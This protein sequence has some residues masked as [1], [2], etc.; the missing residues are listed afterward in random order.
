[1]MERG[2]I[3]IR[4]PLLW[5]LLPMLLALLCLPASGRADGAEPVPSPLPKMA[6]PGTIH[7]AVAPVAGADPTLHVQLA[8]AIERAMAG[9]HFIVGRLTVRTLDDPIAPARLASPEAAARIRQQAGGANLLVWGARHGDGSVAWYLLHLYALDPV[10]Q[11]IQAAGDRPI[12]PLLHRLPAFNP[13]QPLKTTY[14]VLGVAYHHLG[15][16]GAASQVLTAVNNFPDLPLAERLPIAF[17]LALSDLA[18]G[19]REQDPERVDN[20]LYLFGAL[21]PVMAGSGNPELIGATL[22]N[23]G[24][25]YRLHPTR[26]GPAMLDRAVEKFEQALPYYPAGR[27][28]AVRARILHNIGDAEQ[29]HPPDRDGYHL[30]RALAAY[31]KALR[32]WNERDHPDAFRAALHNMALCYQ[33]L[34]VGDRQRNLS[35]AIGL[36][37]RIL[38][39]PQLKHRPEIRAA[40]W[41]NLGQAYQTLEIDPK[42]QNL[43]LAIAAYR[44]A[45]RYW[46]A[47]RNPAQYGRF[48]QLTG[49][50]FQQ[51]PVGDRR[52]NLMRAVNH[53]D[54]A[55]KVTSHRQQ[56]M[57]FAL[58]QVKRGVVW[59][60]MPPP[61]E[62][63]S[64]KNAENAFVAALGIL[65]RDN[66]PYFHSKVVDNLKAVRARLAELET[67]AP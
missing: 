57:Q 42:G 16:Y 10:Y 56:P 62:R 12:A 18:L 29:R 47:N 41:G 66:L 52:D 36:Y 8:D 39:I 64:L 58:I 44:E 51:M 65:T 54:Q 59:A 15:R 38:A 2:V 3:Q 55:L 27:T 28:P 7:I 32:F 34:P 37:R 9:A 4:R 40:T 13:Q 19:V 31:N 23:H 30:H 11:S 22:L 14:A 50:A 25:A 5:L 61:L 43:W 63:R 33:R 20:A 49:Q 1:M 26:K 48:H 45:L 24:L 67:G 21:K 35:L 6:E 17:F 53:F 46:D 60:Q